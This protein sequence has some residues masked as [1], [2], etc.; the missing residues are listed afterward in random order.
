MNKIATFLTHTLHH[1]ATLGALRW[2]LI[3]GLLQQIG[4]MQVTGSGCGEALLGQ[5]WGKKEGREKCA[6]H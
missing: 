1:A 4:G 3:A 6:V 5:C 2:E